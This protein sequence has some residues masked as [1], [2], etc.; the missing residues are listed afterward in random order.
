[1]GDLTVVDVVSKGFDDLV[2]GIRCNCNGE[3]VAEGEA[4]EGVCLVSSR[5][6]EDELLMEVVGQDERPIK[7]GDVELGEVRWFTSSYQVF[8]H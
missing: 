7:I 5:A 8:H 4:F 1:M 6:E 3:V 2:E